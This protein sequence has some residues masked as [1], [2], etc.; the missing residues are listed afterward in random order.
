MLGSGILRH[1]TN[2][3]KQFLSALIA[4]NAMSE[5]SESSMTVR[6]ADSE[7]CCTAIKINCVPGKAVELC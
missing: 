6:D 3:E 5:S 2:F 4:V 7:D 1:L